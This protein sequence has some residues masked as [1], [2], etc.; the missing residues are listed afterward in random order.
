M[1]AGV[2]RLVKTALL[3]LSVVLLSEALPARWLPGIYANTTS[4]ALRFLNDYNS[5]AEEVVFNSVSAS[6][7]YDTN[8]TDHNSKLQDFNVDLCA[9][10]VWKRTPLLLH[11]L[12]VETEL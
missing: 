10:L 3:L 6:W 8:L 1:A 5:T 12:K 2:H 9:C 7:N 4:D 11:N